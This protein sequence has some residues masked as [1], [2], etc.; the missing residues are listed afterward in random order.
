VKTEA[1][2]YAVVGHP[3]THS[4]SPFIHARFAAQ[5]KQSLEYGRIDVT[6]ERF[7]AVVLDFFAGGGRGLNVTVPH[8]EA[9]ARLAET[10][11]PRAADAGAVNTLYLSDDG[12]LAGDNTDGVGLVTDIEANRGYPI[13]G[14]HVLL[15]GA[16]GASRG[17]VG[18]ILARSPCSLTIVNRR[19]ERAVELAERFASRGAVTGG[20]YELMQTGSYDLIVNATSA[21][22]TGSLPPLPSSIDT[23][24]AAYD[25]AYSDSGTP[26]TRRLEELGAHRVW[27]GYGMLVEQAAE[28]FFVWRGIRPDTR[29]VL[30]ELESGVI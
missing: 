2:R 24:T 20:D 29:S 19:A 3:V 25:M 1:D 23:N 15:L 30:G 7:E 8:K 6:P 26:F 11:T 5:T 17:V 9:A 21:S 22:L 16:G 4:R 12:R 10:L 14:K 27:Q 18:P 28:A 13:K